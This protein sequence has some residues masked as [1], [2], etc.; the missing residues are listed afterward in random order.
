MT[1]EDYNFD[2]TILEE[3]GIISS[4]EKNLR[5]KIE[6]INRNLEQL[7]SKA[8]RIDFE[9]RRQKK[10]L[11]RK[12]EELKKVSK[13]NRT[14]LSKALESENQDL[15]IFDINDSKLRSYDSRLLQESNQLLEDFRF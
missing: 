7:Q 15:E 3:A 8:L 2:L 9:I 5:S 13:R 11:V 4:S 1:P 6:S 12:R 14:R 10:S